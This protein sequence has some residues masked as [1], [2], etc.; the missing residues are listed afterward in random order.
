V[1][2]VHASG[3]QL[4]EIVRALR[5]ARV[6]AEIVVAGRGV[7][8]R[9]LAELGRTT[10]VYAAS[11]WHRADV[12]DLAVA[13]ERGTGGSADAVT[14]LGYDLAALLVDACRKDLLADLPPAPAERGLVVRRAASG[15]STVVAR[16]DVPAEAPDLSMV[17]E[18]ALA[19]ASKPTAG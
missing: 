6:Q 7:D 15:R 5:A 12:P 18:G 9:A 4:D 17:D 11:A 8:E 14:A 1:I 13:L 2:A 3:H 19:P 10:P 16:R